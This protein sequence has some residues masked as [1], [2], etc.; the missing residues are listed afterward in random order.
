MAKRCFFF[1]IFENYVPIVSLE[2]FLK[3]FGHGAYLE[4]LTLCP[5]KTLPE[6]LMTATWGF[7]VITSLQ[8]IPLFITTVDIFTLYQR[9]FFTLL[10]SLDLQHSYSPRVPL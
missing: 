6:V 9:K 4:N 2:W 1:F 5:T 3:K 10:E 7:T 8:V